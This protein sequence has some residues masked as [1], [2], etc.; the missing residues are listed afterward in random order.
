MLLFKR[1]LA[2]I[3]EGNDLTNSNP[4]SRFAQ[5]WVIQRKPAF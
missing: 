1:H 3:Y 5:R 4:L 2:G